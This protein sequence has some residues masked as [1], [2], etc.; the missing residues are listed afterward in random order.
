MKRTPLVRK[1]PLARGTSQLKRTPLA[2]QSAKR[3]A[4]SRER[5]ALVRRVLAAR[6]ICE[7]CHE[8]RSVDVHEPY[9][10]A[11]GGSIVDDDNTVAIC[12]RCHDWVHSHPKEASELGLLL[13]T[14]PKVYVDPAHHWR[15]YGC[16]HT[17]IGW[18]VCGL[19]DDRWPT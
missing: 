18:C 14:P 6:P 1:T 10:R 5:A 7:R 11:R 4:V 17:S 2:K 3:V 16:T 19:V 9:T 12:R 15:T 8:A 13:R